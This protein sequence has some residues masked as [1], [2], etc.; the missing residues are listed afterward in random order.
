M[1]FEELFRCQ[2][3]MV[4]FNSVQYQKLVKR[5]LITVEWIKKVMENLFLNWIKIIDSIWLFGSYISAG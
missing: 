5:K 3:V 4:W 2:K 1:I